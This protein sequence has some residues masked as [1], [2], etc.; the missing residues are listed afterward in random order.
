MLKMVIVVNKIEM[1]PGKMA[2]Q[3]AHAAVDCAIK[4]WKKDKAKVKKW[5]EEGQKKV[6]LEASEEEIIQLQKKA[7]KEK[8]FNSLIR[9]AGLTELKEGTLTALAIGPDEEER[10]DKITGHLPLK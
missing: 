8:I 9:D 4:A 6:V 3:V 1:S 7:S 10:I 5:M 2:A